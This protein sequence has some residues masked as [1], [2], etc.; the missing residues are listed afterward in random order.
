MS[1]GR[2]SAGCLHPHDRTLRAYLE[3]HGID[4]DA[5]ADLPDDMQSEF[6]QSLPD[7][8]GNTSEPSA[9]EDVRATSDEGSP[10]LRE[11]EQ[12]DVLGFQPGSAQVSHD[13]GDDITGDFSHR[14]SVDYE[15]DNSTDLHSDQGWMQ[16]QQ[17]VP[18]LELRPAHHSHAQLGQ[19][20]RPTA[21]DP[22]LRELLESHGIDADAFADMP[23]DI[24]SEILRAIP[25]LHDSA[26]PASA[27]S[28][29]G[30]SADESECEYTPQLRPRAA[31]PSQRSAAV[32][33]P[34]IHTQRPAIS[35]RPSPAA[36]SP[37]TD[38]RVIFS[39]GFDPALVARALRCNTL[40]FVISMD[41]CHF[42]D[43]FLIID[44]QCISE[45]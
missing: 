20:F 24:Q 30:A 15:S 32:P 44:S 33:S 8:F 2:S 22:E 37:P 40:F 18:G 12:E 1:S 25:D 26:S 7:A 38:S 42:V 10:M 14:E 41:S 19:H 16:R 21:L 11:Q 6:L 29:A 35:V 17:A 43:T 4:P 27:G 13:S 3:S 9:D 36:A 45:R 23:D 5:F 39:M 28:A 31:S 34:Q